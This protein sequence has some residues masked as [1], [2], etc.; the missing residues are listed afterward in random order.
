MSGYYKTPTVLKYDESFN[1]LSWGLPALAERQTRR[2]RNANNNNKPVERFK[3]HLSKMDNK[4]PL[5]NGFD[6]KIAITDYLREIGQVI[7]ETLRTRW[8]YIDFMNQVLIIMTVNLSC[9][10]FVRFL[11]KKNF[12]YLFW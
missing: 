7:I 2:N 11:G 6:Y 4:P 12:F 5:P 9:F 3:L 8:N 1:L 10:F